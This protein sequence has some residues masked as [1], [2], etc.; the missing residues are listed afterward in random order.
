MQTRS[1]VALRT[2]SPVIGVP[3]ELG[4][5]HHQVDRNLQAPRVVVLDHEVYISWWGEDQK[6]VHLY[7]LLGQMKGAEWF[8]QPDWFKI[9]YVGPISARVHPERELSLVYSEEW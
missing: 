6:D 4:A 9:Y 7:P 8:E 1:D 2:V 3:A 5:I